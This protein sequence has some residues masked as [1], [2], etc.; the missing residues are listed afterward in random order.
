MDWLKDKKNLPI[1]VGLAV[2]MVLV[3]GGLIA[4]EN[5]LFG[6]PSTTASTD[7]STPATPGGTPGNS[8]P[9]FTPA[10]TPSPG[11]AFGPGQS[12][13]TP[14]AKPGT[15]APTPPPS[16]PAVIQTA[17]GPDPFN[18]PGGQK[19]IA[20]QL[21]TIF[22]FPLLREILPPFDLYTIH[23]PSALPVLPTQVPV[24]SALNDR[25]I[26][27]SNTDGNVSAIVQSNG[28]TQTVKPGD[29]LPDGGQVV[30]IQT[31]SITLRSPDGSLA[32]IPLSTGGDQSDQSPNGPQPGNPIPFT[33]GIPITP[34]NPI[35]FTPGI[36]I[37]PGIPV[38]TN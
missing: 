20:T 12:G 19:R 29:T 27:V 9:G 16:V 8:A 18:I 1:V 4:W 23:Q 28:Q 36:P 32:T 14:G 30:S 26:G 10:I 7:A 34:G 11:G 35:P 37:T 2:V 17:K 24:A 3:A 25:L 33:P 22:R 13:A 15:P 31:S 6:G 38:P 21:Q 5:G